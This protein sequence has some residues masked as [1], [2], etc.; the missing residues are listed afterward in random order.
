MKFN[1][2]AKCIDDEDLPRI[3]AKIGV[4]EDE[5]HAVLD[6][7]TRGGG[8]DSRGRPKMLFEPHIF[9]RELSGND[10]EN[11]VALGLAYRKWGTKCY[12]K[13]SYAR[14]AE[15]IKIDENAALR[16][17]SWGLGQIMGFNHK[18]AGY[19]SARK[20]V[21]AFLDDEE[22]HLEAMVEFIIA[23]GLDDDMRNHDWRGF[24]RGYNGAGYAKHG[25][26]LKLAKSHAKWVKIPDTPLVMDRTPDKPEA[27]LYSN[28]MN[29]Y[30]AMTTEQ[31]ERLA[32]MIGEL[33][34]L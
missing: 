13:D 11:A 5:I 23:S 28:D 15:A 25:Y 7:E 9:Y 22:S 6:V 34:F 3:G 18:L 16:S 17:A 14:L 24:A 19:P 4:G 12:P 8:F 2:T 30:R 1:G 20:M 32:K 33:S 31:A 26:H 27:N 29:T 10:R 21:L